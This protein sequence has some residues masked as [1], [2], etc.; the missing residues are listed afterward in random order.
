MGNKKAWKLLCNDHLIV[1]IASVEIAIVPQ[2][3]AAKSIFMNARM[4]SIDC[5]KCYI[6]IA[7]LINDSP[8]LQIFDF[9]PI[10]IP[11]KS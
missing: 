6:L 4:Y 3:H 1:C 8:H 9:L 2:K 7:F 11:L 10:E 5:S